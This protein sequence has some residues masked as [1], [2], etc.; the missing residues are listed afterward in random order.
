MRNF[1]PIV[2][3]LIAVGVFLLIAIVFCRPALESGVVMKQGDVSGWQGMSHQSYEYKKVHGHVPLW[4]TSMFSGM[5]GYQIAM[6]GSYHPLH[7]VDKTIQLWLPKPM[8]FFFLAC[9]CF[10]FLCMTL[11]VRPIAAIAG[12]LGFAYCSFSPIIITAGHETQMYA[13]AYCPAV[14]GAVILLLEKKYLAGFVLTSL[15]SALQIAQGHQQVSYYLFLVVA[16]MVIAYAIR[17]FKQG[18]TAHVAK[19]FGMLAG[20]ARSGG[21]QEVIRAERTDSD[22][23]QGTRE[24]QGRAPLPQGREAPGVGRLHGRSASRR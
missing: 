16:A 17:F 23:R 2:P 3:H 8:N 4:V 6:E 24:D 10:Y 20:A 9:I 1:K 14:I 19:S 13:L 22:D 21:R 12:A 15:F 5:P 7:L 18:E 11:R